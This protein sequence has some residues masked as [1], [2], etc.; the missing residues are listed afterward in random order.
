MP[1]TST[2]SIKAI[3]FDLGKVIVDFDHLTICRK[4]AEYSP[5]APQQTYDKIF[6]S[7][8]EAQFDRGQISPED[9]FNT[10]RSELNINIGIDLFR[11]IWN[12]IFSLNHGIEDIIQRLKGKYKLL[13]LSNTNQWQFEFCMQ[14]FPVLNCFDSF[15]L[16]F[17]VG[18]KKPQQIIFRKA[19][20]NAGVFPHECLY[21]DDVKEFI[22]AAES[23]QIKG[24]Q[25]I[26]VAQLEK[27]LGQYGVL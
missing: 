26:S 13:C 3:I 12:N 27:E 4:L 24:I 17:K 14:A 15:I 19:V 22:K 1:T 2:N 20:E 16:S 18:E 11:E 10:I 7:G 21:I 23:M 9:F 25:F 8:L 6:T 5:C